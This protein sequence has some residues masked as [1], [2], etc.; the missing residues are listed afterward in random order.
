MGIG[1][2][3][4]RHYDGA[5]LDSI[6]FTID[7]E[8][9]TEQDYED[10]MACLTGALEGVGFTVEKDR[11]RFASNSI[12]EVTVQDHGGDTAVSIVYGQHIVDVLTEKDD[13]PYQYAEALGTMPC[14]VSAYAEN[15]ITPLEQ[16]IT[17]T[18]IRNGYTP[19]FCTGPYTVQSY[20]KID[21]AL[22]ESCTESLQAAFTEFDRLTMPMSV[23]K[24]IAPGADGEREKILK[25]MAG[26]PFVPPDSIVA[27][28]PLL[29]RDRIIVTPFVPD[30]MINE[31]EAHIA[32]TLPE[33]DALL[34]I[35]D[36]A[37]SQ[38]DDE[39]SL[40][41]EDLSSRLQS[42]VINTIQSVGYG[43]GKYIE[44][45]AVVLT[46]A[47]AMNLDN[48]D[49][50]RLCPDLNK[51]LGDFDYYSIKEFQQGG[52]GAVDEDIATFEYE[53]SDLTKRFEPDRSPGIRMG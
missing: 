12:Y 19:Q 37:R 25:S 50:L 23:I 7:A 47:E 38:T 51:P 21:D 29:V 10:L 20:S 45:Y 32:Y 2:Y 13:C 6:D 18:L 26:G 39:V 46:P 40:L 41:P 30:T 17:Q 31:D 43:L 42:E 36:E 4:P 16:Y 14:M 27:V 9:D 33:S 11:H 22:L 28:I 8:G 3:N 48:G 15:T 52:V 24:A 53:L 5:G 1:A 35:R 44:L 49:I 34:A